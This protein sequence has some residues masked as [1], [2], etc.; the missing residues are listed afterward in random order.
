MAV[1][2]ARLSS[3]SLCFMRLTL[4]PSAALPWPSSSLLIYGCNLFKYKEMWH[5]N[6]SSRGSKVGTS[7]KSGDQNRIVKSAGNC[8]KF[9]RC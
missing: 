7:T 1:W 5:G 6:Q 3:M 9:G 8:G 4:L 2:Y